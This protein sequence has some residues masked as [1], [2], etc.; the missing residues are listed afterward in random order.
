MTILAT[1]IYKLIILVYG[2][3]FKLSLI[4]VKIISFRF[5]FFVN[6]MF[7]LFEIFLKL[8]EHTLK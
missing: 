3:T 5:I 8:Q 2:N 7:S 4:I 6:L 1:S